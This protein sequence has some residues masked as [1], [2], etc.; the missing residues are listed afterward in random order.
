MSREET[1]RPNPSVLVGRSFRESWFIGQVILSI[2]LLAAGLLLLAV[3][4]RFGPLVLILSGVAGFSAAMSAL[5]ISR[6]RFQI[7]ICPD[8]FL[9]R[10]HAGEREFADD[11]VICAS[12]SFRPNYT[13]GILTSTTRTFDVWVESETEPESIKMVNRL[14]VGTADPLAPLI[15]R[16]TA[17][18]YTRAKSALEAGQSFEGEGWT[19]HASE[20]VVHSGRSSESVRFDSLAAADVFDN[21]LCVWKHGQDEPVLRIP[22][23]SANTPILLKLLRERIVVGD[24]K[25]EVPAGDGLGRVLFERKPGRPAMAAL[26]LMPPAALGAILVAA[27]S[28]LVC[29]TPVLLLWGFVVAGA[30]GLLWSL[31]LSQCVEFR[32]HEHGVRRKLFFRSQQLKYAE[33]DSF[34]YSA[35][36]QYVK[37]VYSGTNF[38]LTFASWPG[39]KLKKLTYS[40]RL[41]NADAALEHLRDHVSQ[42][43]A[44]RMQAQ[45][46]EGH[47]VTWTDGLRFLA[48]GLEYRAAGF[49]GRKPP[50]TI[51][52]SQIIGFDLHQGQFW[53]WTAGKKN[54]TVKESISQPNFFP[55]YLFL[56]RLL[57]ARPGAARTA[58][59]VG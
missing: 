15:E 58:E 13:D 49:L 14:A 22:A 53:L 52:Y 18:L 29:R 59:R 48:E 5:V 20:L 40:K 39:G 11:Q 45:F 9:V 16:I 12:L 31:V 54:A 56:S 34:T 19:L 10:K 36:R 8:G 17:H 4:Q 57:A 55:G 1:C 32:V 30:I 28:A 6:T 21:Q 33:V 38:T 46:V 43:I 44:D 25:D 47:A 35:V 2:C 3:H 26:W 7:E 24:E 42:L 51:P 50:V 41:R 37:G 23:T 27:V